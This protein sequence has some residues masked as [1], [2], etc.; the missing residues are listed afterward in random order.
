MS[1]LLRPQPLIPS[2]RKGICIKGAAPLVYICFANYLRPTAYGLKPCLIRDIRPIPCYPK[3]YS[4]LFTIYLICILSNAVQCFSRLLDKGLGCRHGRIIGFQQL[5]QFA[6]DNHT[7]G[8]LC[9][10]RS[11][12]GCGDTKADAH[13]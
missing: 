2:Q 7:V 12:F 1:M 11:L 10:L 9:Y 13:R 8:G 6:A 5:D 3:T 4:I